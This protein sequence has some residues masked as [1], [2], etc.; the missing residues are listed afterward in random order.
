MKVQELMERVGSTN[1][2]LM[3]AYIKDGLEEM[4]IDNETSI[5]NSKIDIVKNQRMYD[6]PSD[7]LQI[8]G[9]RV[10]NNN[11]TTGAYTPVGR[12]MGKIFKG[13]NS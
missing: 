6:L 4:N 12:I 8:T 7:A 11:T 3:I 10:K 1:T 2:G 9:V 5:T 13:D